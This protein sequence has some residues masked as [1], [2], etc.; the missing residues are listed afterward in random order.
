[1]A[2]YPSDFG[3]RRNTKML[4]YGI[5]TILIFAVVITFIF[6]N[7]FRAKTGQTREIAADANT[8]PDNAVKAPLPPA[9]AKPVSDSNSQASALIA[10]AMEAVNANPARIIEARDMLNA[11][12]SMSLDEQQRIFVKEQMSKLAD[13]WLFSK[14]IFPDDKLCGVYKV[15][16]GDVL[17]AIGRQFKVP[18]ELLRDINRLPSVNAIRADERLKVVNGSFNIKVYR[19]KFIMDVYLNGTFVR[20]FPVGL[21]KEGRDTPTG[22]WRARSDGKLISP[23]WTDPD[24]GKRY[25]PESPDYPLGSRWIGLEGLQGEAKDRTGFAIHGTKDANEIGSAKSRGCIRLHNGDVVLVY[26]MLMGGE[27][28]VE[29]LP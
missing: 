27:S 19:S 14:N 22:I 20:S 9:A 5:L 3:D 12:L 17:A 24:T 15:L 29:V 26:N 1:M 13:E 7:P 28:I 10:K 11:V 16:P 23:P 8:K 18:A 6:Y 2:R 21:G 4:I 25:E